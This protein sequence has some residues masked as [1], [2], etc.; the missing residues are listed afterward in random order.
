M[1]EYQSLYIS[2]LYMS[3][4]AH[5]YMQR[6][7]INKKRC[8]CNAIAYSEHHNKDGFVNHYTSMIFGKVQVMNI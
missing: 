3:I 1:L 4:F 8:R 7:H 6:N 2:V 5:S